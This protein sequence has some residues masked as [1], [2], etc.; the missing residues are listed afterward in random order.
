[1]ILQMV[2]DGM[3]LKEVASQWRRST[4]TLDAVAEA[5]QLARQAL[6]KKEPALTAV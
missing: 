6:L 1:M 4:V 3:P 5:V 2:A